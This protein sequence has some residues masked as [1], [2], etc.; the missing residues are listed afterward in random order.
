MR[1]SICM[2]AKMYTVGR[3]IRVNGQ[4]LEIVKIQICVR[5]QIQEAVLRNRQTGN[6]IEIPFYELRNIAELI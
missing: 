1:Y 4:V 5:K 6:E 3:F 2:E